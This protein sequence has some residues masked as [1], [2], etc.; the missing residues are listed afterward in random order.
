[1][2]K[3]FTLSSIL[4]LFIFNLQAQQYIADFK[5]F[6]D[7][8]C[9]GDSTI[10]ID[11]SILPTWDNIKSYE[12]KVGLNP[13]VY[14]SSMLT[15]LLPAGT[16]TIALRIKTD[17]DTVKSVFKQVYVSSIVADFSAE[18]LCENEKSI[19]YN[20]SYTLNCTID[21]YIWTFDNDPFVA[22]NENPS[23]VF[24]TDGVH[25]VTLEVFTTNGCYSTITQSITV[26][27]I[28]PITLVFSPADTVVWLGQELT[29]TLVENYNTILWSTGATS[30]NIIITESGYYF[31]EVEDGGCSNTKGFTVNVREN[32]NILKPMTIITPNGDGINDKWVIKPALL[33]GEEY[34]VKV[35][36]RYGDEVFSTD[37]YNND[38]MGTY[39]SYD[40][41]LL[42]EGTYY[43][44]VVDQNGNEF[45]G[46]INI[47]Y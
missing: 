26:N 29:V 24:T 23:Y 18:H 16:H 15:V 2:K 36:N 19:F 17:L 31:V 45:K 20:K 12:W 8:A 4:F 47:L 46:P 5:Y 1:M 14:G 34:D 11:N 10:L 42:P 22:T 43:Y 30:N 37:N 7:I 13:Y 33:D 9:S 32:S 6:D 21:K 39:D 28:P 41:N 3:I 35:F 25:N 27:P 44:Y 38:W 40:G